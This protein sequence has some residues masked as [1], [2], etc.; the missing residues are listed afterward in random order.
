MN[1]ESG[2]ERMLSCAHLSPVVGMA[3]Q[4]ALGM[5]SHQFEKAW[6]TADSMDKLRGHWFQT[7]EMLDDSSPKLDRPV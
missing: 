6:S 3:T 5:P 4:S 1:A 2:C 7:L